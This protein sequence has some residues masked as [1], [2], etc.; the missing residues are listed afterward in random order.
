MSLWKVSFGKAVFLEGGAT[1]HE[2]FVDKLCL[3]CN[4]WFRL[5]LV[6]SLD[7]AHSA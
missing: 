3:L 7:I 6:A 2:R 1:L 4:S 5:P